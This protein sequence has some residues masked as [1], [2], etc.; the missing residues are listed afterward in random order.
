M[1]Q[2]PEGVPRQRGSLAASLGPWNA[3][4]EWAEDPQDEFPQEIEEILGERQARGLQARC[5]QEIDDQAEFRQEIDAQAEF[6]Q[7]IDAQAEFRQEIDEILGY[8][9]AGNF[10]SECRHPKPE[11]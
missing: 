6:P 4:N 8:R 9:Q 7:E 1:S 10:R 11:S 5:A 3:W 2:T